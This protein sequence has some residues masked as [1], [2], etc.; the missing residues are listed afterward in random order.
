MTDKAEDDLIVSLKALEVFPTLRANLALVDAF[1]RRSFIDAEHNKSPKDL[2]FLGVD[3]GESQFD[4]HNQLVITI[5]TALV[6][7]ALENYLEMRCI[8][9]DLEYPKLESFLN[10]FK[11]REDFLTGMR[12]IRN[13]TFHVP[14]K[15]YWEDETVKFF[16]KICEERGGVVSV[17]NEMRELLYE[18]TGK[19]FMGDLKI[20]PASIYAYAERATPYTD[21]EELNGNYIPMYR[22]S[23]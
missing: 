17:L 21:G 10:S 23:T 20:F 16:L 22:S 19:C 6:C 9:S 11:K 3:P 14:R 2:S 5:F 7:Q 13:A 15:R 12:L 4:L 18:F 1:S 8:K